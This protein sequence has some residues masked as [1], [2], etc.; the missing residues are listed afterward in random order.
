MT[1]DTRE[2]PPSIEVL[3]DE[4]ERLPAQPTAALRLLW[5]TDDPASSSEDLAAVV[6]GDPALTARIMRMANSVY[7]GLSGRVASA[8]F[9]VTVLGFATVRS[10]AAAAAA[11]TLQDDAPAPAGFWSHA[12]AAASAA[13]MVAN[14]VGAR[15]P[16]AFSVGLLHDL[17]TALLHRAD[18]RG[19]DVV[20][21]RMRDDGVSIGD[22]ERSVFGICHEEVTAR[23]LTAWR[24]PAEFVGAIADHHGDPANAATPLARALLAGEALA[25]RLPGAPAHEA[26]AVHPG[27]LA[28]ANIDEDSV[29]ALLQQIAGEA[30]DI[31]ASLRPA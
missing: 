30:S 22:A 2:A 1:I 23:V 24:F 5:L 6:V 3:L 14:R 26:L 16:E 7:Y 8:Q 12:A 11:G 19:Y 17:G 13:A 25:L 31:E 10:L 21:G 27:A 28:A 15:R 18:A 9:A 4:L 29:D 20:L